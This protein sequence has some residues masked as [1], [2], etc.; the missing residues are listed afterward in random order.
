MF[1]S[2]HDLVLSKAPTHKL[3][4]VVQNELVKKKA[5]NPVVG[6]QDDSDSPNA[7]ANGRVAANLVETRK[8]R[9]SMVDADEADEPLRAQIAEQTAGQAAAPD[10]LGTGVPERKWRVMLEMLQK[11]EYLDQNFVGHIEDMQ[12]FWQRA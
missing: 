1:A 2:S 11:A 4:G 8:A 12:S 3:V 7:S 10:I 5:E 6:V 9:S